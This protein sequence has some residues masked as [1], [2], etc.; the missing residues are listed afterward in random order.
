MCL[1]RPHR[2]VAGA[3]S[4]AGRALLSHFGNE[5]VIESIFVTK[6]L[7]SRQTFLEQHQT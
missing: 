1:L 2:Y 5:R 6:A 4:G 7:H 3:P